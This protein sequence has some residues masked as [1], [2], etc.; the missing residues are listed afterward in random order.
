MPAVSPNLYTGAWHICID[1]KDHTDIATFSFGEDT[2]EGLIEQLCESHYKHFY[3][4]LRDWHET[5]RSVLAGAYKHHEAPLGGTY[6]LLVLAGADLGGPRGPVS[7]SKIFTYMLL[8][9]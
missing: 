1:K 8:L 5:Y 2:S 7:P 6:K 9:L 3:A 4:K